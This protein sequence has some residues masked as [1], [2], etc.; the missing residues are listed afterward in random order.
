MATVAI[1]TKQELEQIEARASSMSFND[2]C[3][4][5]EKV[6]DSLAALEVDSD[7]TLRLCNIHMRVGSYLSGKMG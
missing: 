3:D 2:V 1:M 5:H 6:M 4:A 7:D